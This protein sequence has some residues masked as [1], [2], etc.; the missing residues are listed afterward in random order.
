LRLRI[1]LGKLRSRGQHGGV[2]F[3]E[4]HPKRKD[5]DALRMGT[6]G[7]WVSLRKSGFPSGMTSKKGNGKSKNSGKCKS[8]KGKNHADT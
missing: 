2:G 4:S 3:V 6:L 1:R 5:R 8:K 7:W